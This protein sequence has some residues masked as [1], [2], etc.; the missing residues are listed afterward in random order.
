MAELSE[1]EKQSL[2]DA[3]STLDDLYEA[4]LTPDGGVCSEQMR[5]IAKLAEE[6]M[7][8]RKLL[9]TQRPPAAQL[10]DMRRPSNHHA[11]RRRVKDSAAR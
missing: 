7:G 9:T 1:N 6:A 2:D 8:A 11:G 3:L 5:A 4:T 10:D